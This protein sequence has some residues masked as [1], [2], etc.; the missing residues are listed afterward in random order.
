M[1]SHR[2]LVAVTPGVRQGQGIHLYVLGAV[3]PLPA[4]PV[5]RASRRAPDRSRRTMPVGRQRLCRSCLFCAHYSLFMPF[6]PVGEA[7]MVAGPPCGVVDLSA[8]SF[9][10]LR[11]ARASFDVGDA[12]PRPQGCD[13]RRRAPAVRIADSALVLTFR[14]DLKPCKP[15]SEKCYGFKSCGG[16]VFTI[17]TLHAFP[18]ST[19]NIL[20]PPICCKSAASIW[21]KTGARACKNRQTIKRNNVHTVIHRE[22]RKQ[23]RIKFIC[24]KKNV[25]KA[26]ITVYITSSPL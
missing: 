25:P 5:L 3:D 9:D 16:S 10:R 17:L 13:V 15:W 22:E 6:S 19:P 14:F 23:S 20:N 2:A 21:L 12:S 24:F 7:S 4:G 1:F 11:P 18:F 8:P 26:S